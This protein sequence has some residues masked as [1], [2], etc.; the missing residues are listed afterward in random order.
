MRFEAISRNAEDRAFQPPELRV[1]VAK[2]LAF[3][4]AAGRNVFRIKIQDDRMAALRGET[5]AG[6]AGSGKFEVAKRLL[7]HGC[8]EMYSC[9]RLW[10]KCATRA[11][12]LKRRPHHRPRAAARHPE[13]ACLARRAYPSDR[14][15]RRQRRCAAAATDIRAIRNNRA[16]TRVRHLHFASLR[17]DART[18][19][20]ASSP[21]ARHATCRRVRKLRARC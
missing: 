19:A 16:E 21:P 17:A 2:V 13:T 7:R 12:A 3:G 11:R 9:L 6:I 14:A 4:R 5:E 1:E 20:R 8:Y 18:P 15:L 10:G